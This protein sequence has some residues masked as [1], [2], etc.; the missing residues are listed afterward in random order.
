MGE[1]LSLH[2]REAIRTP[3]QWDDGPQ[4]RLLRRAGPTTLVRPVAHRGPF[5]A[6]QVNV[7]AQQRDPNSFLRWFENLIRTLREAPE[8]GTGT[9]TVIDVP[10]PPLGAGPPNGRAVRLDPAA[11]QPGRRGA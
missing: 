9:C 10:L 1:D 5:G 11:A 8:I 6:R 7:R 3:M 2:G 4:R